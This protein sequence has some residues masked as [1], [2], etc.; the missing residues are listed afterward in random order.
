[1]VPCK[2]EGCVNEDCLKLKKFNEDPRMI[3][4]LLSDFTN[5]D[6]EIVASLTVVKCEDC[7]GCEECQPCTGCPES[8]LQTAKINEFVSKNVL[9]YH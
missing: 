5:C 9:I 3:L 8:G 6:P 4:E 7:D 1:M 2:D